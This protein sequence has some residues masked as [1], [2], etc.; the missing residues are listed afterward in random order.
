MPTIRLCISPLC[1]LPPLLP[2][3]LASDSPRPSYLK[4]LGFSA[5]RS[6]LS[7][8]VEALGLFCPLFSLRPLLPLGEAEE[9]DRRGEGDVDESYR[10]DPRLL[11][12]SAS[13]EGTV[14]WPALRSKDCMACFRFRR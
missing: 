7:R 8:L 4:A 2:P 13:G 9:V 11:L 5:D 3:F 10:L 12:D 14:G 6:L 1:S